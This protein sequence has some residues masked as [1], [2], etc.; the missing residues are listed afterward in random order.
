LDLLEGGG[1]RRVGS[2]EKLSQKIVAAL[3]SKDIQAYFLGEEVASDSLVCG[4]GCKRVSFGVFEGEIGTRGIGKNVFRRGVADVYVSENM[5]K[6]KFSYLLFASEGLRYGGYLRFEFPKEAEISAVS[7]S[8]VNVTNKIDVYDYEKKNAVGLFV[9]VG[10]EGKEIV[11]DWELK[12]GSEKIN[13]LVFSWEKQPGVPPWEFG[14]RVRALGG[15]LTAGGVYSYNTKL[16]GD[17]VKEIVL[18][19]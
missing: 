12:L 1:K 16:S 19:K 9:D 17:L 6:G 10:K 18:K 7:V 14:L 8:G 3:Y 15:S 5:M 2:V 4:V 13:K 11:F